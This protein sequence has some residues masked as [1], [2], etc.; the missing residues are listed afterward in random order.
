MKI[1]I[2]KGKIEEI[3]NRGVY[4]FIRGEDGNKYFYHISKAEAKGWSKND[5]HK[6]LELEFTFERNSRGLN[7]KE[8]ITEKAKES[9]KSQSKQN[10]FWVEIQ[11]LCLFFP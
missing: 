1:K 5:F 9:F 10:S 4:G 3:R 6:G 11:L 8:F 7:V 2:M